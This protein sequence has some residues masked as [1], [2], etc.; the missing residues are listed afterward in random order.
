[1][2]QID[3]IQN[4]LLHVVGWEQ[5]SYEDDKFR[6]SDTLTYSE[7]GLFFQNVHPLL[8][9][10][11]LY[12]VAPNFDSYIYCVYDNNK[13]Y[14]VGDI[15]K[16]NG[17]LYKCRINCTGVT[18]IEN[19]NYWEKINIF[20]EWLESKTKASIQKAIS[21]FLADKQSQ[22]SAKTL[23]E[24]RTL[25]DGTGRI[26]DTV[27][28]KHNLVG[29]EIVPVRSYG[30]TTKIN[31]I[32]LQFTESGSYTVYV[33]HSSSLTPVKV[34][35]LDRVHK[36]SIEW[37]TIQDLYLPY[38]TANLDA[39]GS[40][41][42]CYL[43][44]GLPENSEAIRKEYDWSKGPCESCS[45]VERIAWNAWS[46]YIEIHPFYVNEEHVSIDEETGN[47]Q[48]WDIEKNNYTYDTNY[49]LNLD[50]TVG[51]DLTDFIVEQRHIFQD[52]IIKQL[53]VDMLREFA[54]NANVRTN[55][56]SINAS[57]VDILYELDGDS[58]SM[59]QSGLSFQLDKAYKA[60]ELV[61]QGIDRVCMPCVNN[62]IKYRTV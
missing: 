1:M 55:R 24:S 29:F 34:L 54:Y 9:L 38:K 44:S 17:F 42:I 8:T 23:L 14:K 3:K 52:V 27:K 57:R 22:K 28:N 61:T 60:V 53:A 21:R 33:M 15:I 4:A 16:F 26:V 31:R 62:G 18:P 12:C 39:G 10:Q 40:W 47:I 43:Q 50:I 13:A 59:K 58:A 32:G 30:V 19:I 41:Y 25:F 45:R 20:S 51:C 37:F 5:S 11:N 56:H 49:G 7:S 6:L 36:N 2:I 46:K 35:N 48:M